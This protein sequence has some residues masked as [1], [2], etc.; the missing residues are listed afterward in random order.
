M[1]LRSSRPFVSYHH[2]FSRG[3]DSDSQPRTERKGRS[4]PSPQSATVFHPCCHADVSGHQMIES[5][6]LWVA[7]IVYKQFLCDKRKFPS[8]V[9]VKSVHLQHWSEPAHCDAARF[10]EFC[11]P[12]PTNLSILVITCSPIG[13]LG[14]LSLFSIQLAQHLVVVSVSGLPALRCYHV[15]DVHAATRTCGTW[16]PWWCGFTVISN[17]HDPSRIVAIGGLGRGVACLSLVTITI[18]IIAGGWVRLVAHRRSGGGDGRNVGWI[19][20][21]VS[22]TATVA[23]GLVSSWSRAWVR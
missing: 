23:S 6:E 1:L 5:K 20:I 18:C 2:H 13:H 22:I 19:R 21:V 4:S 17:G 9:H 16:L 7:P 3:K 14:G 10:L 12:T 15:F 11:P 8:R